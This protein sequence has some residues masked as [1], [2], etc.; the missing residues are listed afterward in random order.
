MT[1]VDLDNPHA[2]VCDLGCDPGFIFAVG[3]RIV[4][5]GTIF[6]S[7]AGAWRVEQQVHDVVLIRREQP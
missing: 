7:M 3:A 4:L 6:G 2:G 5:P 1:L